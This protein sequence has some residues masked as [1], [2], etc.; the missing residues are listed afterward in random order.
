MPFDWLHQGAM[1]LV[2]PVVGSQVLSGDTIPSKYGGIACQAAR[3][4][5]LSANK[6]DRTGEGGREQDADS[7][8]DQARRTVISCSGHEPDRR[9]QCNDDEG[10]E[11]SHARQV[12]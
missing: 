7:H 9:P 2:S 11:L 4:L 6:Q 8:H 3:S 10:D 12:R 1:T 5:R